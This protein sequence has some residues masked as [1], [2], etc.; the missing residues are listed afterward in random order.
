MAAGLLGSSDYAVQITARGG[1]PVLGEMDW[2]SLAYTRV[3]NET[4]EASVTWLQGDVTVPAFLVDAEP[5]EHD[6]VLWRAAEP[7]AVFAGP[8]RSCSYKPGQVTVTAKDPTAWFERRRIGTDTTYDDVDLAHIFG[9]I[10][11]EALAQDP[12]P[13]LQIIV[14]PCGFTGTRIT[15]IVERALAADLMRELARSG[16]DWT[17][18]GRTILIGGPGLTDALGDLVLID[19]AVDNPALEKAGDATVTQQTIRWQAADDQAPMLTTVPSVGIGQLGLL[20]AL[21]EEADIADATSAGAAAQGRLDLL[22]RNPRVVSC[23]LTS[24]AP[25]TIAQL[26]PGRRVDFRLSTLPIAAEGVTRLLKLSVGVTQ[27]AEAVKITT[28]PLGVTS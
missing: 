7:D 13:N 11:G 9:A 1:T 6:L 17:A 8:I 3:G 18:V 22:D 2:D 20:E 12:S 21:D 5:W 24:D 10:A 15:R 16:V 4:G 14:V 19:E 27:D 28:T 26:V 25:A 23:G